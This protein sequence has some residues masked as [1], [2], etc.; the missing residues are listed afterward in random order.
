VNWRSAAVKEL[1]GTLGPTLPATA[2]IAAVAADEGGYAVKLSD[3][4][5]LEG[6]FEIG[7]ITKTMTGMVL[8]A[9]VSAG[10]RRPR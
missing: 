8:A 7:S 10:D 4:C 6:R 3:S 2:V 1:A 5:P 9:L